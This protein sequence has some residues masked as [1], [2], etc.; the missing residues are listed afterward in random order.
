MAKPGRLIS[1]MLVFLLNTACVTLTTEPT[2]TDGKNTQSG[3]GSAGGSLW[4]G[5]TR[6]ATALG[7]SIG[8]VFDQVERQLLGNARQRAANA[9]ANQRVN[10]SARSSTTGKTT[11]GYVIPGEI[12]TNSEGRQCRNLR[13]VTNKDGKTYEETSVVCKSNQGW[14]DAAL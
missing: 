12:H 9:K 11:K 10:W 2:G 1:A 13:Q 8:G 7:T 6:V 4:A 5:F 3:G 14:E